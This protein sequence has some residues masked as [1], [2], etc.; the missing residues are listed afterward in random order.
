[1]IPISFF[2]VSTPDLP[3]TFREYK[4]SEEEDIHKKSS[5]VDDAMLFFSFHFFDAFSGELNT[6]V[7][8][9]LINPK[10]F[11][12]SH[13]VYLLFRQQKKPVWMVCV[14]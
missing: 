12:E 13:K 7:F 5:K 9:N 2:F 14:F 11:F 4:K 3:A 10:Q 6:Y 1:M 8:T